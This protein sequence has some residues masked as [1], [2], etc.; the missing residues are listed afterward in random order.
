VDFIMSKDCPVSASLTDADKAR[1]L[2]V[3]QDAEKN[4]PPAPASN[5]GK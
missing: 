1:L 3:K 2:Q 4:F 5:N